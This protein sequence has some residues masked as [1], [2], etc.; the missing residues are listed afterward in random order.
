MY[1]T[2]ITGENGNVTGEYK[3]KLGQVVLKEAMLNERPVQTFYVYD[4]KGNLS[5]VIPPMAAAEK[6]ADPKYITTTIP[7]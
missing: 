2:K 6:Q 4:V 5:Y 3:D 1:V 7:F